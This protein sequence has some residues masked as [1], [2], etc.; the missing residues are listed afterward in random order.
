[1]AVNILDLMTTYVGMQHIDLQEGNIL[2]HLLNIA[3]SFPLIA[4]YKVITAIVIGCLLARFRPNLIK[5]VNYAV[6]LICLWNISLV[7]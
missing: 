4:A 5:V 6:L 2:C 7:I 1:M 3:H